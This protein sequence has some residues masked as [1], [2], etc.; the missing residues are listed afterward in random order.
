MQQKRPG[1]S[2]AQDESERRRKAEEEARLD[3]ALRLTFPASDPTSIRSPSG[4]TANPD[5]GR[6]RRLP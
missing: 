1:D 5:K 2:K 6:G 3:E 4:T